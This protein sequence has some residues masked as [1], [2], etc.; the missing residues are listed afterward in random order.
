MESLYILRGLSVF[1]RAIRARVKMQMTSKNAQQYNILRLIMH[2]FFPENQTF[3]C[4][5]RC[6]CSGEP[7]D[8]TGLTC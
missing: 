4:V 5:L 8:H 6:T 7:E 2:R 3:N 1:R